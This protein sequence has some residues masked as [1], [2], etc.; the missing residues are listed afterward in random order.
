MFSK[1]R[2]A[3]FNFSNAPSAGA[4]SCGSPVPW[5]RTDE[6]AIHRKRAVFKVH[7]L[8]LILLPGFL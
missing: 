8:M 5:A 2:D 4:P 6:E 1:K 7:I 3:S